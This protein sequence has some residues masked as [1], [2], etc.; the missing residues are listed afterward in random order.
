VLQV[1][2][3]F[4]GSQPSARRA[5]GATDVEDVLGEWAGV[6]LDSQEWADY[7]VSQATPQGGPAAAAN[8]WTP[9][10]QQQ[11]L[12][13]PAGGDGSIPQV[14]GAADSAAAEQHGPA[15]VAGL[16]ASRVWLPAPT[17]SRVSH[18]FGAPRQLEQLHSSGAAV[19]E[20]HNII[21]F[22]AG[23]RQPQSRRIPQIDGAGD[24]Q[25][26]L[27]PP[28]VSRGYHLSYPTKNPTNHTVSN[29][30]L[31]L[32]LGRWHVRNRGPRRAG[33]GTPSLRPWC[34]AGRGRPSTAPFR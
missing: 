20:R 1:P 30:L 3:E 23:V 33:S 25:V 16:S 27:L 6:A 29:A 28:F 21:G 12:H 24:E 18:S 17:Q 22:G 31:L 26:L 14:D 9:Q 32:K 13:K 7:R 11:Q 5:A 8:A 15:A 34:T 2:R 4:A 10:K 19:F